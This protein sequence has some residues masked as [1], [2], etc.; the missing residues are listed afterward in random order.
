[1]SELVSVMSCCLCGAPH[2]GRKLN[3]GWFADGLSPKKQKADRLICP[4]CLN[5]MG[6]KVEKGYAVEPLKGSE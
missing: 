5:K 2:K 3:E 4:D 6:V 1:M